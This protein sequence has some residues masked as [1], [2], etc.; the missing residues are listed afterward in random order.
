MSQSSTNRQLTRTDSTRPS[1]DM[2]LTV[3]QNPD[4]VTLVDR[5]IEDRYKAGL[6]S[7]RQ[8]R[9]AYMLNRNRAFVNDHVENGLSEMPGVVAAGLAMGAQYLKFDMNTQVPEAL[10]A[11]IINKTP[12]E[13]NDVWD[14][15]GMFVTYALKGKSTI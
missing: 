6:I 8:Y 15:I 10:I 3:V 5:A 9:L 1:R 13:F 12:T 14:Q 11:F 4:R 7:E 2:S